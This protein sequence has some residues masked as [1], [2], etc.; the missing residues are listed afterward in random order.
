M[1][2]GSGVTEMSEQLIPQEVLDK[3]PTP[4]GFHLLLALREFEAVSEGGIVL[5]T[6]MVRQ[7]TTASILGLVVKVGPDAY[8]DKEK[9]PSGPWC[10][11]G[12]WVMFKSYA[13]VRFKVGAQEFRLINDDT[14]EAVVSDPASIERV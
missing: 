2:T 4:V 3:L 9:F 8:N 13:G 11:E 7:E 14:V 12:D 10:Q 6:N 5:S 1:T